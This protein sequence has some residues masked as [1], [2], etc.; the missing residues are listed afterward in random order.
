MLFVLYKYPLNTKSVFENAFQLVFLFFLLT[1][2]FCLIVG[3]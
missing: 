2:K 3:K 1:E